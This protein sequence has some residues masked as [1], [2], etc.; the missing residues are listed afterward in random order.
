MS[1][2]SFFFVTHIDLFEGCFFWEVIRGALFAPRF[3]LPSFSGKLEVSLF[4]VNLTWPMANLLNFFW[5]FHI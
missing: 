4:A 5:G 3:L 2:I 1:Q